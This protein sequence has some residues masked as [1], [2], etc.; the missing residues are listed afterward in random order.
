VF[1]YPIAL[2]WC[3]IMLVYF[4]ISAVREERDMERLFPDTYPAYK[5]RSKMLVPFVL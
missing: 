4:V 1:V 5:Q 2:T 3:A